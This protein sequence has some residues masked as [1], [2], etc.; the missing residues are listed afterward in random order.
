LW[1]LLLDA[2]DDDDAAYRP[3]GNG[4]V[5]PADMSSPGDHDPAA[6]LAGWWDGQAEGDA[7]ALAPH[8]RQWPGRAAVPPARVDPDRVADGLAEQVPAGHGT[9]RL[10]LVAA[11]RG[12]DA[13]TVVGWDGPLDHTGDTARIS[14]VLRDW[15]DRF[16]ARVVSV[17]FAT[18]L[19]SVAAPPTT[20]REALAVAAEHVAFCP[21]N[22]RQGHAP[23]T[24]AGYADRIVGDHSWVFW[25]D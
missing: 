2:L 20:T 9:V 17:G 22:V 4:E 6:L 15:E 21:D 23:Q 14:A 16:G 5:R 24:L 7:G 1:P 19:L 10:G 18:L 25:W 11:P 8:G 13:P 3:W 12:A